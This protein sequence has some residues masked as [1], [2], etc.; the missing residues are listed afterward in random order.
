MTSS[1]LDLGLPEDW[2]RL[3]RWI[4]CKIKEVVQAKACVASGEKSASTVTPVADWSEFTRRN[5]PN[6]PETRINSRKVEE[7]GVGCPRNNKF[8]FRSNRNKP[9]LNLFWLFFSLFRKTQKHFFRFVSVFQTGIETTETNRTLSKQTEK[10][11]KKRSLLGGPRN[12]S[13]FF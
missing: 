2:A 3:E 8:V 10:I 11:F 9:K 12:S 4:D 1:G 7:L 13:I 5:I 6:K